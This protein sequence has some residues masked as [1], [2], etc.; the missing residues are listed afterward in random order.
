V[1]LVALCFI[2]IL[3]VAVAS[4]VA[5]CAQA[6]KMSNRSFRYTSSTQL[7]ESGL[8]EA[9]WTL[10]Q[11]QAQARNTPGY[12]WPGW[13][14][15]GGSRTKQL[16]GF[17]SNNGVPGVVNI[18]V[19]NFDPIDPNTNPTIT[20][21]GISQMTDGA[22]IDKVLQ[23]RAR[24]APLFT[25]AVGA[26]NSA[27][28]AVD[29]TD[30][31]DSYDSSLGLYS[32]QTPT[33]QAI[34]SAPNVSVNAAHILGYVATRGAAPVYATDGAVKGLDTPT[35]VDRDPNRI[36]TNAS[37]NLFEILPDSILNLQG[38]FGGTLSA[39]SNNLNQ[40]QLTRYLVYGDLTL[41][42]GSTL[43]IAGPVIIVVSGN[44]SI[45]DTSS[46]VI[47]SSG[48]AQ[49]IVTGSIDIQGQGIV[50]QTM[51]PKNLAIFRRGSLNTTNGGLNVNGSLYTARLATSTPFYGVIYD[52]YGSLIAYGTSTIYGSLVANV[53]TVAYGNGAIHYDLDLRRA[54]FSALSTSYDITQ[55]LVN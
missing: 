46:I 42:G 23:V 47:T 45:Q 3:G 6:M 39:G 15:S 24:S 14:I 40:S 50:N 34:V 10:N 28:F 33:D 29:Y 32:A 54:T 8:E 1:V 2:T 51:R 35:G 48:S 7:A 20:A 44:L 12:G 21:H 53:V 31:L 19:E 49:I 36:F 4:Y 30:T 25:G 37:Q 17:A 5:L 43:T 22:A 9:L 41:S 55:W 38:V 52:P 18:T 13:T 26:Y 27:G 11:A 16:T